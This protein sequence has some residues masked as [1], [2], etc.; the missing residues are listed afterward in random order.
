MATERASGSRLGRELEKTVIGIVTEGTALLRE[1]VVV[2]RW[3]S[4]KEGA[5]V[6]HRRYRCIGE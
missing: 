1:A 5:E 4:M 2:G 3:G 6:R